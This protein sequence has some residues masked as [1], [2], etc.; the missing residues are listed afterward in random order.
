MSQRSHMFYSYFF[1]FFNLLSKCSSSPTL[2][3]CPDIL[4]STWF[5]QLVRFST[6]FFIWVIEV[7][8]P[9]ISIWFC[10]ELLYIY[11]FILS[12]P[13]L[14]SLFQSAVLLSLNS[15]RCLLI[16][17]LILLIIYIIILWKS[18]SGISSTSLSLVC[19][20]EFVE[21]RMSHVVLVFLSYFLCFCVG[22]C[23][24]EVKWLVG[25]FN[26]LYSFS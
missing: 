21:F 5:G 20:C 15:F 24:S 12:Y 13:A 11:W 25:G 1:Y 9:R 3:S 4:S 7:F 2:F 10:S 23:T 8:I 16:S 14:S 6:K 18:L 26:H 19:Y 17:S 22:I